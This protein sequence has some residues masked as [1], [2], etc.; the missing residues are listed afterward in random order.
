MNGTAGLPYTKATREA[1]GG[2]REATRAGS[3]PP[4]SPYR[5]SRVARSVADPCESCTGVR[6]YPSPA[7]QPCGAEPCTTACARAKHEGPRRQGDARR[8]HT[9]PRLVVARVA[10]PAQP[11]LATARPAKSGHACG[12]WP[13]AVKPSTDSRC[14]RGRAKSR[15]VSSRHTQRCQ[16]CQS[17]PGRAL[18]RLVR[19]C[20]A[21]DV[22]PSLVIPRVS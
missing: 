21:S 7:L 18:P 20:D 16:R 9:Q 22:P 17:W 4:Q 19:A 14:L 10:M 12:A 15:Q 1:S 8:G 11:G 13:R 6:C 5:R 3:G 2:T